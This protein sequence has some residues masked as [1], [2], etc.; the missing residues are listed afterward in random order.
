MAGGDR[1]RAYVELEVPATRAGT[2]WQ[3]AVGLAYRAVASSRAHRVVGETLMV[4]VVDDEAVAA[5]SRDLDVH[6]A[7]VTAGADAR[8]AEAVEAWRAGRTSEA[9]RISAANQAVLSDV[10]QVRPSADVAAR[11]EELQRDDASFRSTSPSSS[12]GRAYGLEANASRRAR[13]WQQ[14]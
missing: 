5:A 1:R 10:Q 2:G 3:V 12:R 6:A 8:Q 14:R 11:L 7:A 4:R 9:L 13:L